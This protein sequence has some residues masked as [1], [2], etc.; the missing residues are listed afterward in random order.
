MITR[1]VLSLVLL[2]APTWALAATFGAEF[3][4]TSRE[5]M[6]AATDRDGFTHKFLEHE[7][8]NR[9]AEAIIEQCLSLGCKVTEGKGKFAG[10]PDFTV[11]FPDGWWFKVSH[12]PSV[13]EIMTK[14]ATVS[15]LRKHEALMDS[16]LFETARNLGLRP[17]L[18]G[19]GSMAG[20]FNFG[21]RSAFG[22]SGELFLKF[23]IDYANHPFLALGG[24]GHDIM[25]APPLFLLKPEFQ[26]EMNNII[27]ELYEDKAKGKSPTLISVGS[28]ILDRVYVQSFDRQVMHDGW[29]YQAFSIKK[30]NGLR[31][32]E[33]V[34]GEL[35]SMDA[36]ESMREFILMAELF[37]ARLKFLLKKKGRIEYDPLMKTSYS[38]KELREH[39]QKYVEEAGLDFRRFESLLSSQSLEPQFQTP[40]YLRPEN[41]R[42]SCRRIFGT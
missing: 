6:T 39:F 36:Q 10:S 2:G 24:L 31:T 33:D 28:K 18:P 38:R 3:E 7:A 9:L 17:S 15:E 5:I 34:P 23:F 11:T 12:D 4:F 37:E 14:P 1:I 26:N 27:D 32:K 19:Y 22:D 8:K 40:K 20:H 16:L 13:I 30:L 25:N 41:V 35:R 29:H 42:M 21:L